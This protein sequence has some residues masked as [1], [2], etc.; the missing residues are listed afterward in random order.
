MATE[1][2]EASKEAPKET[3]TVAAKDAKET[4]AVAAKDAKEVEDAEPAAGALKE[5]KDASWCVIEENDKRLEGEKVAYHLNRMKCRLQITSGRARGS[6][7]EEKP[8]ED[9]TA[10]G[11]AKSTVSAALVVTEDK[12]IL[13]LKREGKGDNS[14]EYLSIPYGDALFQELGMEYGNSKK[15][16]H[17]IFILPDARRF[18]KAEELGIEGNTHIKVTMD[19]YKAPD[20]AMHVQR[21]LH[22]SMGDN[23]IIKEEDERLAGQEVAYVLNSMQC[24]LQCGAGESGGSAAKGRRSSILGTVDAPAERTIFAALAVTK[25][26]L[27]LDLKRAGVPDAPKEYLCIAYDDPLCREV[28]LEHSSDAVTSR[29]CIILPD[30][31]RFFKTSAGDLDVPAKATIKVF[32]DTWKAPDIVMHVKQALKQAGAAAAKVETCDIETDDARLSGQTPAFLLNSLKCRMIISAAGS[33]RASISD[34]AGGSVPEGVSTTTVLAALALCDDKIVLD[35]KRTGA[36]DPPQEYLS[37]AYDKCSE[38]SFE[39]KNDARNS[40]LV[41]ELPNAGKY[42]KVTPSGKE[43]SAGSTV[44]IYMDTY[45][46]PDIS[47]FVKSKTRKASKQATAPA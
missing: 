12:L 47:M 22:K 13:D 31:R 29:L 45:K 30:A 5:A 8:A 46:A 32:M 25:E 2:K 44:R 42:F 21:I 16:S 24:R 35:L 4:E 23:C 9:G 26:K 3:E 7:L 20:V 33:K 41:I 36:D 39:H 14:K 27:V 19:T 17:L 34:L 28:G 37:L 38:M 18:L 40:H 6:I 11:P 15:T 43:I 1:E 10:A